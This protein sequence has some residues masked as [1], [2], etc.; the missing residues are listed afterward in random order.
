MNF[1]SIVHLDFEFDPGDVRRAFRVSS[2]DFQVRNHT[3]VAG[4]FRFLCG[5]QRARLRW[6]AAYALAMPSAFGC[7]S[8]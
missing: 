7:S 6:S 2:S 8:G 5:D 1:A 3:E 4:R